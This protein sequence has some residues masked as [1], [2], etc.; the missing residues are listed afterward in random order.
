MRI[1]TPFHFVQKIAFI[2]RISQKK[3]RFIAQNKNFQKK[4]KKSVQKYAKV[5]QSRKIAVSLRQEKQQKHF[6]NEIY[7]KWLTQK[8]SK[9]KKF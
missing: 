4:R 9:A 2:L 6:T 5:L 7:A 3:R 1:N 8:N